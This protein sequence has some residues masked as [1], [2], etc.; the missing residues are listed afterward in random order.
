VAEIEVQM[1][2]FVQMFNQRTTV[3]F[4][5][6]PAI[7]PNCLLPVGLLSVHCCKPLSLLSFT[8]IVCIV[9]VRA[10]EYF[11]FSEGEEVFLIQ[12]C[13]GGK[14]GSFF[15]SFALCLGLRGLQMC[16]H[17]WVGFFSR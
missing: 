8:V 4:S 14:G 13:Q 5:T 9:L 12:F 10:V 2:S 1:F 3:E 17:L 7:L 16:L 6:E 11:L 15:A